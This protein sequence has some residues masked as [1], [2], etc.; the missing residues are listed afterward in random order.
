M[1]EQQQFMQA[2]ESDLTSIVNGKE[3]N[4]KTGVDSAGEK[5]SASPIR[6]VNN[7]VSNQPNDA[8]VTPVKKQRHSDDEFDT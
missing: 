3:R 2:M 5:P 8:V 4:L 6:K 1:G 7:W